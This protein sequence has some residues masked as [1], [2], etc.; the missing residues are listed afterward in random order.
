LT[1]VPAREKPR[2]GLLATHPVQ[3]YVPWYRLL[4]QA[5]DF[6]VFY[7]HSQTAEGQARAGFGVAFAWDVPLLEGYSHRFLSNRARRPNV[8]SFF[9][10]NTPEIARIVRQGGFD[11]FIVHG[12][13]TL[14]FWQ[15]IIACRRS[16]T[17]LLV[18]GDS[19]LLSPRRRLV[20]AIKW[21]F[22]RLFIPR[23][24][25]YLVVGK[26]ARD[27]YAH[28]GAEPERMFFSPHSVDNDFFQART[29]ALRAE[30]GR[31]RAAW[32]IPG[33][34]TV[35]LFAGKLTDGKRPSDFVRAVGQA[36]HTRPGTWVL[37]VGD[38]QLRSSLEAQVRDADWPVRFAGFLNQT[39]MPRA[40]AAS[41]ALV[42][43]STSSETWGLVVNE[44]MAS[45][46][47][48]I[49]S[50]QVGCGPDLVLPGE[51]GE[52]FA[53]GATAELASILARLAGAP[54]L[55][56]KLGVKAQRLVQRYSPAEAVK[57]TVAAV[58]CVIGERARSKGT[59]SRSV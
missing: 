27:Y 49:V 32:G 29:D 39:E 6:E 7:S 9:G 11:A 8:S 24:D 36:A 57:G 19:Q 42:L 46:L 43:P 38:G 1:S 20:R 34:A 59:V 5:L 31:L 22:Y 48:A 15:A 14:S 54:S 23:F 17:R 10:C 58:G 3:Y 52:V 55:L 40:Y 13:A 21:P 53:C 35:F 47:P 30:R 26:R 50:D 41:D 33:A 56:S 2:V 44:A 25:A 16:G 45:G 28:Y 51:T 18:R 37:V 4:A 12:W